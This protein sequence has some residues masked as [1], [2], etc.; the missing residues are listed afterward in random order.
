MIYHMNHPENTELYNLEIDPKEL[1]N[2]ASQHPEEVAR[3]SKTLQRSGAMKIDIKDPEGRMDPDEL[4]KLRS[5]GYG[6]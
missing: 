2:L 5:L 3:L 6:K 1:N 4:E